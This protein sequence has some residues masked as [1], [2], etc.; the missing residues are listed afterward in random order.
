MI[1]SHAFDLASAKN[2]SLKTVFLNTT[3]KI[4]PS[5]IYNSIGP[6]VTGS[7]LLECVEKMIEF[8]RLQK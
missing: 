4:Y 8:E 2:I 1:G 6:D 5:E 7:S 3:E